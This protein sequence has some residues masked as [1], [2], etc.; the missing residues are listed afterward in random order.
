MQQNDTQWHVVVHGATRNPG[1]PKPNP[2]RL[3]SARAGILVASWGGSTH[4][5]TGARGV[6][7]RAQGLVLRA[8]VPPARGRHVRRL[9][10]GLPDQEQNHRPVRLLRQPPV[11]PPG[12]LQGSSRTP[13]T[14]AEFLESAAPPSH[15]SRLSS[16]KRR[17]GLRRLMVSRDARH[18]QALSGVESPLS[19]YLCQIQPLTTALNLQRLTTPDNGVV[20]KGSAVRRERCRLRSVRRRQ[21]GDGLPVSGAQPHSRRRRRRPG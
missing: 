19:D 5:D 12:G 17:E 9:P 11:A 18:C 14:A 4:D 6:P 16:R 7:C 1:S 13:G 3:C 15:F 2:W 8:A 10:G 21:G 20:A